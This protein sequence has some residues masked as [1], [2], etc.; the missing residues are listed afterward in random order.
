[1]ARRKRSRVL[2]ARARPHARR[3][4][5]SG[6]TPR[7]A[8]R[9]ASAS[10]RGRARCTRARRRGT[11]DR[12][13]SASGR[14]PRQAAACRAEAASHRRYAA[15][16]G[17]WM[18]ASTVS[19]PRSRSNARTRSSDRVSIEDGVAR[20]LLAAHRVLAAG[21]R[22]RYLPQS[23]ARAMAARSSST[24][25]GPDDCR[26]A[27]RVQARVHVVDDRSSAGPP[28]Q[29]PA[30]PSRASSRRLRDQLRRRASRRARC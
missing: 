13:R 1:M 5:P 19:S 21:D 22:D 10:G 11:A 17:H 15:T 23:R 12:R 2:R 18:P 3:R 8:R 27:R 4:H 6:R 14:C 30:A 9:S 29:R 20:E 7:S 25:R 28:V 16:A 24:R 26:D